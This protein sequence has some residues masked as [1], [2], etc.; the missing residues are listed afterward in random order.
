MRTAALQNMTLLFRS[1][2]TRLPT[3]AFIHGRHKTTPAAGTMLRR[4][5]GF[6]GA[7]QLARPLT[8]TL[9][10]A[11]RQPGS[12]AISVLF[13]QQAESAPAAGNVPR[14]GHTP[15]S[16]VHRA[17]NTGVV[18]FRASPGT[19]LL[20]GAW[21]QFLT[22]PSRETVTMGATWSLPHHKSFAVL[23]ALLQLLQTCD[24]QQC[25]VYTAS[26]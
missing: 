2:W 14:C 9:S 16:T 12:D 23:L 20:L 26:G 11:R 25:S 6:I 18:M 5:I 7:P 21:R 19:A 22:D 1:V 3:S 17:F 15:G 10:A 4:F 24:R 8:F 13:A